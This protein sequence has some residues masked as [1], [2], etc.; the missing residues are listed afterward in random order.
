MKNKPHRGRLALIYVIVA[1]SFG[2]LA[3]R[4]FEIQ[5]LRGEEYGKIAKAQSTGKTEIPSRRGIIYDR[6]GRELAINIST[7]SL[8]AYPRNRNEIRKINGYLDRVFGWA[9]GTASHRFKFRSDHFS[10]VKRNISDDLA[11]RIK[12]DDPNGLFLYPEV[13]R[14]YPFGNIGK[15]I[16]GC[17][18]IDG[19][20][21]TGIEYGSDS[22]LAGSPGVVDYLRDG[23]RNTYRLRENP[24]IEPEPGNSLVLTVD[25]YFQEI[26]EE[27][28]RNAVSEYNAKSGM[29]LFLN[30]NS[31]EILAAA[32]YDPSSET[33]TKLGAV[34]DCFEPGSVLKIVAA[35]ALLDE[36]LVEL[37]EKIYCEHGLWKCGR[38]RLRDDKELDTLTIKD[39]IALSSNIGIGK[40]AQRLGGEKLRDT[41]NKFGFGQTLFLDFPGE[42]SGSIGN[43]GVW[44][45]Y[46]I[47]ALSIGHAIAA[48]PLQIASA[49]ASVAN[50]GRLYR[51]RIIGGIINP[52]GKVIYKADEELLGRVMKK[53]SAEVLRGFLERVVDSG[54]ATDVRSDIIKIAGK[55]GTAQIPNPEKGGY[56]WGKYNASFAGYFPADN[57]LVAGIVVLNQP[58]PIHYGGHTSGPTFKTIAE[59]YVLAYC[60]HLRPNTRLIADT[61]HPSLREIPDFVGRDYSLAVKMAENKNLILGSNRD[62]GMVIWQYPPAHREVPGETKVAVLVSDETESG[63][64][65]VDLVGMNLRTALSVLSYQGVRFD[66][67]GKGRVLRQYPVPGTSIGKTSQCRLV[68]GN[69]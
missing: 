31:G 62:R 39:I 48:T 61:D 27:E 35:S 2:F 13:G 18:D 54:T 37:D 32:D 24:L 17:T 33:F 41:Y 20:G 58:E 14:D 25:W 15:Q 4:L 60:D 57:P 28:L 69:G 66:I 10:W 36:D 9:R 51:P 64:R 44:S 16:L 1:L 23:K 12:V 8:Y 7:N 19:K 40:L 59:R 55:T 56:Y 46:N 22:I 45:E 26:V 6:T 30:C 53:S 42:A 52:D 29:A 50:G 67:V 49:M 65:M 38:G 47:A 63:L 68:C 3:G 21:L 5:I 34:S 11:A 43:P